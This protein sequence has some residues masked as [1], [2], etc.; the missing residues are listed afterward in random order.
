MT[1]RSASSEDNLRCNKVDMIMRH[2][3]TLERSLFPCDV[4]I[5]HFCPKLEGMFALLCR[6]VGTPPL[7]MCMTVLVYSIN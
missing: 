5:T 4:K 7:Q 6:L 1:V 2:P 3:P